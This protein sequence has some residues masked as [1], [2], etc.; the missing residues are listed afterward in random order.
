M[1]RH[2]HKMIFY[3]FAAATLLLQGSCVKNPVTG[4]RQLALISTS[5]EIGIGQESHPE[6][7]AEYGAVD[8]AALQEYF[9]RIGHELAAISHRPDLPWTFTV[10][11]S[12]VVNAFAVPG[13]FIY[14]TRGI[15]AYM[16]NEAE[17]AGVLGHEIGHVTARHSVTQITQQ[18]LFGL[19]LGIGSIFSSRFRQLSGLAETGLGI[20]MLKYSRDHERQADQL[21]VEYM[22]EG[23]YDPVQMSR[24]FEV[25][26][27]MREEQGQAIPNWLSSHPAPPNRIK[28]TESAAEKIKLEHSGVKYKINA[29]ALLS[30]IDGIVYGDNPREGFV[31]KSRFYHPDLR[32]QFGFPQGWNVQN[33]KQSVTFVEPEGKA[34]IELT[35]V[36]PEGGQ[37]PE[38]A[39]YNISRQ[40]GIT[41]IEGSRLRLNG[42]SAYVGRYRLQSDTNP[43]EVLAAFIDYGKNLYQLAGMT[44]SSQY[45]SFSNTF[46]RTIRDFR[47]LTDSR[48]LS[49]QPDRIRIHRAKKGDTIRSLWKSKPQS[50]ISVDDIAL[51]N[52]LDPDQA[53]SARTPVKLITLGR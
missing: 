35:L 32:F 26:Q 50:R 46:D 17:L 45:S 18:Q 27:S 44:S 8:D 24:F 43:V 41:L 34:A 13:G 39:A 25:F 29:E 48:I 42:N 6:I 2:L 1:R 23:G 16:N 10:L 33:T 36:P 14:L 30:Q 31:E 40:E 12:P 20:L 5:Q 4:G 52:R 53:L 21:G 38:D 7:I 28:S 19:G 49:V 37:T 22:S 9:S 11:D 15:L 51:L 3:V 47:A